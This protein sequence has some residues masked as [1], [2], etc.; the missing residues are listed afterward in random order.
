MARKQTWMRKQVNVV[1]LKIK[2]HALFSRLSINL[3]IETMLL[4]F[5]D[6]VEDSHLK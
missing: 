2:G 4:L 3:Q 5:E 6:H 1:N